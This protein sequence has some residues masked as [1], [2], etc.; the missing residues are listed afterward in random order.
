MLELPV[1]TNI[2]YIS[3]A[4]RYCNSVATGADDVIFHPLLLSPRAVDV[5]IARRYY[6]A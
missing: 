6:D 2:D 1:V 3:I 5:N 4:H